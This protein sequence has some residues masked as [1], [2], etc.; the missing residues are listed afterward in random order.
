MPNSQTASHAP[1]LVIGCGNPLRGDDAAGV[2]VVRQLATRP[3]PP[4]V[5]LLDAGTSGLEVTLAMRDAARIYF[6]DA[7]NAADAATVCPGRI[8][9][10]APEDLPGFDNPPAGGLSIHT[11]RWDHALALARTLAANRPLP[12]VSCYLIEGST[13]DHGAPLSP[14][15]A[16]AAKRL[17]DVLSKKL[18]GSGG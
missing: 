13:F 15:V 3:L 8:H 9:E 17:A 18:R 14:A 7:A 11:I 5:R 6:I 10:I 12:P 1:T 16:A 2:E 4:Q